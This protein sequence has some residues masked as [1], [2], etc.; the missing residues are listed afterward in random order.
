MFCYA[1]APPLSPLRRRALRR[2]R[3]VGL[4]V[5]AAFALRLAALALAVWRLR[6][7]AAAAAFFAVAPILRRKTDL[8]PYQKYDL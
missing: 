5:A 1:A 7:R 2:W 6:F 3:F 4:A 8:S